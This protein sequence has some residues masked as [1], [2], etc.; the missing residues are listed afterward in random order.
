MTTCTTANENSSNISNYTRK[1]GEVFRSTLELKDAQGW[2]IKLASVGSPSPQHHAYF[3]GT[4]VRT[5][6]GTAGTTSG[7]VAKV[8]FSFK[9]K[10][11]EVKNT[12]RGS[13][14]TSET[15][16]FK[17]E[18]YIPSDNNEED[19]SVVVAGT[20]YNLGNKAQE[21]SNFFK[22]NSATCVA[23]LPLTNG[24]GGWITTVEDLL[25]FDSPNS[26]LEMEPG[27][28]KY[29]V[30]WSEV[31]NPSSNDTVRTILQGTLTIEEEIVDLGSKP[32][33]FVFGQPEAP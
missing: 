6:T 9:L 22:C 12:G 16:Y 21:G 8:P 31:A 18:M 3:A 4:A 24:V 32:G 20:T 23:T 28:W 33:I 17:V 14:T 1:Q 25:N 7:V 11:T 15:A 5:L 19:I 13:N 26:T 29:E 2:A 27:V 10:D 30:R